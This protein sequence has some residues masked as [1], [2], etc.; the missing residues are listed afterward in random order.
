M[1]PEK[2]MTAT[3]PTPRKAK[4]VFIQAYCSHFVLK[5]ASKLPE[6]CV[7][8]VPTARAGGSANVELP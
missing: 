2:K 5:D 1:S 6:N 8:M 7:Q 3:I 4:G